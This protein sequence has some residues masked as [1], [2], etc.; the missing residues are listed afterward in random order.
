MNRFINCV[1]FVYPLVLPTCS[2]PL[3]THLPYYI[4]T[5]MA[6]SDEELKQNGGGK[7]DAIDNALAFGDGP[8][9]ELFG[10]DLS[11]L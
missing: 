5:Q 2:E 1:V 7:P 10:I 6:S 9:K 11:N 3:L 4:P 8:A